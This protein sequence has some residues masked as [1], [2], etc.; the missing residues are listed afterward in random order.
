MK[1]KKRTRTTCVQIA[2]HTT[3]D[4]LSKVTGVPASTIAKRYHRVKAAYP[5]RAV[6]IE[7]LTVSHKRKDVKELL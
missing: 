3:F 6:C 7:M 5:R 1:T 2:I 4:A